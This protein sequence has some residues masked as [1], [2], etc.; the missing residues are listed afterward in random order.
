MPQRLQPMTSRQPPI[1]RPIQHRQRPH[2]RVRRHS[3]LIQARK[4]QAQPHPPTDQSPRLNQA[5]PRVSMRKRSTTPRAD[6]PQL[7][8]VAT[9]CVISVLP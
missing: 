9:S 3:P 4:T 7:S 5:S 2:H 1:F 8:V 6:T